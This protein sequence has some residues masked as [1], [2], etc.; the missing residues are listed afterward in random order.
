ML[1][2]AACS[3]DDGGEG[4]EVT[5]SDAEVAGAGE[6]AG[7]SVL[8]ADEEFGTTHLLPEEAP[9]VAELYPERPAVG[10]P[11][12]SEWLSA[13]VIDAPVGERGAVH[14]LEHGAMAV[15]LDPDL[16]GDQVEAVRGS[17]GTDP[18]QVVGAPDDA[19][20]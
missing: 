9:P 20:A 14:D 6:E 11:H 19:D 4:P 1:L 17:L 5:V 12:F 10:G 7:C 16:D 18:T 13:G 2:V 15:Y 3:S 8:E